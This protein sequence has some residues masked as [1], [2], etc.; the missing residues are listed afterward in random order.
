MKRIIG[1]IVERYGIS[2]K[3]NSL[4]PLRGG[5]ISD[6]Y[7][8]ETTEGRKYVIKHYTQQPYDLFE[9]EAVG[10]QTLASFAPEGLL[11]PKV[12][13]YGSL[14]NNQYLITEYIEHGPKNSSYYAGFGKLFAKLHRNS[15]NPKCGFH[16]NNYIGATPQINDWDASWV[17]FYLEHRL[18][19]QFDRASAHHLLDA[20]T[21]ARLV[22][23]M[24]H[25]DK[26]L[27][28]PEEISL[29][30]G[31]LWGGNHLFDT[32]RRPVLLD[33][34]V[35]YGD[36]EAD[37]AMTELFG[38]FPEEFYDAYR[39]EFP[40]KPGYSVRKYLYQLY[41]ALNHLNL[42]GSGYLSLVHGC[43]KQLKL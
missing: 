40:M 22:K 20:E 32:Q 13:G 18:K 6:A 10:L 43:L 30:H 33:P 4:K 1:E 38:S 19:Y 25:I 39:E 42:F 7:T 37:L 12:T 15:R 28:E 9:S 3:A 17:N 23:L 36:R 8:F 21:S 35:Y 16:L 2:M 26:Y 14:K 27:K 24:D 11:V 31:D 34:A 5:D 29:L 41:H